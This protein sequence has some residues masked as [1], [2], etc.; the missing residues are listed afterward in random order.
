[1]IIYDQVEYNNLVNYTYLLLLGS[2]V[3]MSLF[4]AI[5][6]TSRETTF[7][8]HGLSKLEKIFKSIVNW[9]GCVYT[10]FVTS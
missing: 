10:I 5:K 1:M 7:R 8:P 4:L 9:V 6:H 3:I 2:V